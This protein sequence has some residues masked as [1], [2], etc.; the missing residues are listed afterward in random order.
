MASVG[1]IAIGMAA[2]RVYSDGRATRWSSMALWSGLSLLPDIDVIGFAGGGHY[3][4]RAVCF[5]DAKV[6]A[7][8]RQ[9]RDPQPPAK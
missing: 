5:V 7:V 8:F 1:H 6:L 2:A 9:W 3:R 4:E